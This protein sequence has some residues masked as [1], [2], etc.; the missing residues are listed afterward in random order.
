MIDDTKKEYLEKNSKYNIE[1]TLLKNLTNNEIKKFIL[2]LHN[3][4]KN[5]EENIKHKEKET[6]SKYKDLDEISKYF[7][8]EIVKIENW[9]DRLKELEKILNTFNTHLYSI[10]PNKRDYKKIDINEIP[11]ANIISK[12]IELP[13]NMWRNIKCPLHQDNTASF[14]IYEKTNSFYCF[15]CQKWWNAIN[16]ISF[17]EDISTKEAYKRLID[18]L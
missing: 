6:L 3:E 16:F 14:K 7:I 15:W 2:P 5:I 8:Q 10:L 1:K 9:W 11:I 17:I 4:Y 18:I 13:S 12:Y